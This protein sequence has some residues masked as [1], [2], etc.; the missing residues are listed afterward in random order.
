MVLGHGSGGAWTSVESRSLS[1]SR[2]PSR[3]S[4]KESDVPDTRDPRE[5]KRRTFKFPQF[6]ISLSSAAFSYFTYNV[7]F[8]TIQN[9]P[10]PI[11]TDQP[12]HRILV[13]RVILSEPVTPSFTCTHC[14]KFVRDVS[15]IGFARRWSFPRA[16]I[17]R[18]PVKNSSFDA[19]DNEQRPRRYVGNDREKK[20]KKRSKQNRRGKVRVT[21]DVRQRKQPKTS[22]VSISN[23]YVRLIIE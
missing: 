16:I 5:A 15:I 4:D 10:P 7:A 11:L 2:T 20:K 8:N 3:S 14:F 1:R 19:R 21:I 12:I 23:V 9:T 13:P 22:W 6:F 18:E 17:I